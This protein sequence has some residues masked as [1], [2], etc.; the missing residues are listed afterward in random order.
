M[1][2]GPAK[3]HSAIIFIDASNLKVRRNAGGETYGMKKPAFEASTRC[4]D[5]ITR[6]SCGV[7]G[8]AL[9]LI[10]MLQIASDPQPR[11]SPFYTPLLRTNTGK[12][13]I[14]S[15]IVRRVGAEVRMDDGWYKNP[16]I[17]T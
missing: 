11:G 12:R 1:F 5:L 17:A 10:P 4:D 8:L 14:S 2:C 15:K 7:G 3:D 13:L 16:K 6:P 9:P